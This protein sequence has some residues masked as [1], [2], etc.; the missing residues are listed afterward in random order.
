MKNHFNS[1][2]W[3]LPAG[4]GKPLSWTIQAM[5]YPLEAYGQAWRK[6]CGVTIERDIEIKPLHIVTFT[7]IYIY[8]PQ[9]SCEGYVFTGMLCLSTGGGGWSGGVPGPREGGASSWGVPGLGVCSGGCLA[10]GAGVCSG[11]V[12]WSQGGW[13]PSM[14][15]ARPPPPP[16]EMATAADGTHPTA[17]HSCL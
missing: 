17:M 8:R 15:W 6:E 3:H 7:M 9:R 5:D 16:R 13:Y 4:C 12:V 14:Y 10:R 2:N 1:F 11:G